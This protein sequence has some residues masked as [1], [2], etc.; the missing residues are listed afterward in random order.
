MKIIYTALFIAFSI[1]LSAQEP[2]DFQNQKS[3]EIARH[4]DT[5]SRRN[6]QAEEPEKTAAV[7]GTFEITDGIDSGHQPEHCRQHDEQDR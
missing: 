6:A 7:R 1:V 5:H 4:G 2:A 3:K